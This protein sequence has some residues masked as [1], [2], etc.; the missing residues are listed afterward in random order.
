M[1]GIVPDGEANLVQRPKMH[2]AR[3][4]AP[5]CVVKGAWR[6]KRWADVGRKLRGKKE[7]SAPGGGGGKEKKKTGGR[8]KC[9]PA[10]RPGKNPTHK[11][12]KEGGGGGTGSN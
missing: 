5:M 8:Q 1:G 3:K 9:R 11:T 7:K 12:K 2:L 4:T 6:K 10:E